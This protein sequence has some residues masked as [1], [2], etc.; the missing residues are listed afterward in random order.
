TNFS[1]LGN[2][3]KDSW[4]KLQ[5]AYIQAK[6]CRATKSGQA[7]NSLSKWK[8]EDEMAFLN[9][10]LITRETRGNAEDSPNNEDY[11]GTQEVTVLCPIDETDSQ[12]AS[13]ESSQ[14]NPPRNNLLKSAVPI[15]AE[16]ID[17]P[18]A[19]VSDSPITFTQPPAKLVRP[20]VGKKRLS[21]SVQEMVKIMKDNQRLHSQVLLQSAHATSS[22]N[23]D[24]ECELFFLSM[25]K[26]VKKFHPDE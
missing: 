9:P 20:Y 11:D 22:D 8:F 15:M 23:V 10:T 12:V 3:C 14:S 7:A 25:A 5:N 4:N 18:T 6:H 19:N 13:S 2:E 21:S 16:A 1:V 26:N 17:S 24:N